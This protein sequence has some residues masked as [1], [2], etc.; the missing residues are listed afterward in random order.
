[1]PDPT[2]ESDY[3]DPVLDGLAMTGQTTESQE[4]IDTALYGGDPISM[5]GYQEAWES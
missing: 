5:G 2:P 1:M 4:E 3:G